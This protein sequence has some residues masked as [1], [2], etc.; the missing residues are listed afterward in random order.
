M[1]KK[2]DKKRSIGQ[3]GKELSL[4]DHVI[5]FWETQFS[6]IRPKTGKGNRRY[7]Y[8]RDVQI[9]Q[10]IRYFLYD[11]GYTIKGLQKLIEKNNN[12]LLSEEIDISYTDKDSRLENLSKEEDAIFSK[13]ELFDD[14]ENKENFQKEN[15]TNDDEQNTIYTE[16][17]TNVNAE[18]LKLVF[19]KI[20]EIKRDIL[21][22]KDYISSID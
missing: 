8:E 19:E 5:R 6:Q 10:K 12:L 21:N 1:E 9:I 7:Y 16:S 22:F 13:N 4:P 3:V 18:N 2:I 17:L 15:S 14:I 11:E 20:K